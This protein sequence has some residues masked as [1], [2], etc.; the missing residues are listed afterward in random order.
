MSK[1]W[2]KIVASLAGRGNCQAGKIED[3]KKKVEKA[4]DKKSGRKKG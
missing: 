2:S 1:I 4:P 3:L